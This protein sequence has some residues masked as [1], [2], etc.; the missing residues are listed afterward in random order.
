MK[1]TIL[2]TGCAGFV[3]FHLTNLLINKK[4]NVIG[5][6]N[7]NN[8]YDIKLKKK[9]LKLLLKYN[10][11]HFYKLDIRNLNNLKKYLKNFQIYTIYHLAAQAG[12]RHSINFPEDYVSNNING[13]FNIIQ[14]AKEKKIN[15]IVFSSTSSVY[16]DQKD[17]RIK[18]N[19]STD[20]PEQFYAASKKSCEL[21]L[22][23]YSKMYK[24]K[25]TIVRFFTLYGNF[26]RPDMA[27]FIFVKNLLKKKSIK[28]NNFGEHIR[29]FTHIDDAVYCLY[30]LK[31]KN[32][33]KKINYRV[34]NIG[35]SKPVK[36]MNYI[37]EIEKNLK[38][39]AKIIFQKMQIGDVKTVISN[40][41][42]IVKFTGLKKRKNYK[43]G[44][45]E[46]VNWYKSFYKF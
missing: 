31:N 15:H 7:L 33:E 22:H 12:V 1:K 25:V 20:K 44:V 4:L 14:F 28:V 32:F 46:F 30:K 41:E 26:G 8:Y 21:M 40:N 3:G 16:G 17:K 11:F 27:L 19:F 18:E 39:K 29:D 38:I 36:L 43:Q 10:N 23:A 42:K 45:K 9:R 2:V 37:K 35:N 13:T 34:F 24:M 5:I 6:D